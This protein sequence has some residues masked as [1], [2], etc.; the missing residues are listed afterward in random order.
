MGDDTARRRRYANA[1]DWIVLLRP[2]LSQCDETVI[3]V[4]AVL[5]E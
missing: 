3:V 1:L 2:S 4:G 5:G